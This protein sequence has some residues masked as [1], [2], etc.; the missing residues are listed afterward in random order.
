MTQ[1]TEPD[2]ERPNVTVGLN[3][4]VWTERPAFKLSENRYLKNVFADLFAAEGSEVYLK[5][6]GDY[7]NGAGEVSFATLCEAALRRGEVAIGYRIA[8]EASEAAVHLRP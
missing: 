5:P 3:T 1:R 8:A 7:V 6:L 2:F 4:P